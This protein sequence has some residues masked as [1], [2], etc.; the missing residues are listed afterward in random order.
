MY[1]PLILEAITPLITVMKSTIALLLGTVWASV[2]LL[3]QGPRHPQIYLAQLEGAEEYRLPTFLRTGPIEGLTQVLGFNF[4]SE[5]L[6][7]KTVEYEDCSYHLV[8]TESRRLEQAPGARGNAADG[9]WF[10]LEAWRQGR[11]R[12]REHWNLGAARQSRRIL[13]AIEEIFGGREM[14]H[15]AVDNGPGPTLMLRFNGEGRAQVLMVREGNNLRL[16]ALSRA[17]C[18]AHFNPTKCDMLADIT[19][20]RCDPDGDGAMQTGFQLEGLQMEWRRLKDCPFLSALP[21]PELEALKRDYGVHTESRLSGGRGSQRLIAVL[22]GTCGFVGAQTPL[23]AFLR[24]SSATAKAQTERLVFDPYLPPIP[25]C[26]TQYSL[27]KGDTFG[28]ALSLLSAQPQEQVLVVNFA[29]NYHAG[30]GYEKGC[31]AQEEDLF[32][33]STLPWAFGAETEHLYPINEMDTVRGI[34]TPTCHILR[35]REYYAFLS[36]AE[37]RRSAVSVLSVAA[38]NRKD[39]R[40]SEAFEQGTRRFTSLGKN[41]TLHRIRFMF[42][43]AVRKGVDTLIVGAFGCG[44]FDNDPEVV[45][46]LFNAAMAEYH[47]TLPKVVF[48]IIGDPN[49]DT[50]SRLLHF[51]R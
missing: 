8:Y 14:G 47:N 21:A 20:C 44:A 42:Q 17:Q 27:V 12:L 10:P 40:C 48:A 30:G 23:G 25:A 28:T 37:I 45:A 2:L 16:P 19:V 32:R 6:Y 26:R 15:V 22:R 24:D 18:L 9:R 1:F 50:F 29:N 11:L 34:Y 4:S 39:G 31:A 7:M 46:G 49:Y 5:R 43:T 41:V 3:R 13:R 35:S 38:F 33:C 51:P 36:E